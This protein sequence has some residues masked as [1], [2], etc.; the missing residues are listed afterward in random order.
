MRIR[1]DLPPDLT[2]A[3]VQSG[4]AELRPA[5]LQA[6][7]L[8]RRALRLPAPGPPPAEPDAEPRLEEQP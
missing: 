7:V 1:L 3:L 2:D 8:L 6:E 4:V 5:D